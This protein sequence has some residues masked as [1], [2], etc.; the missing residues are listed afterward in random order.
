V[1]ARIAEARWQPV[2]YIADQLIAHRERDRWKSTGE[3]PLRLPAELAEA[4]EPRDLHAAI[5][6]PDEGRARR[7][8]A[9]HRS[10]C[11]DGIG[12]VYREHRDGRPL[13]DPDLLLS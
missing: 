10:R 13:E 8:R 11:S 1:R 3:R 6:P 7:I 9:L 4:M 5:P 2:E 12:G